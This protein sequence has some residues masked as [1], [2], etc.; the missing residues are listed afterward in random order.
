[1][2]FF[3]FLKGVLSEDGVTGSYSR[4]ASATIV[5]CTVAWITFLV[6]RTKLMPDLTGPLAFLTGG[7]GIHMGINKASEIATAIKGTPQPP[8]PPNP[9]PGAQ[10]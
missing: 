6:V 3:T 5:F 1:M 7:V 2:G 9:N 10:P 8:N 4:C